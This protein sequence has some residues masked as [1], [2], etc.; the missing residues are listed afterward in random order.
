M[1]DNSKKSDGTVTL[2]NRGQRSYDLANGAD[3]KARR[4]GPGATMTYSAEEAK[5]MEGY[6]ELVDITKLPGQVDVTALK[7]ENAKLL[8]ENAGLK[9]QLEAL[10]DTIAAPKKEDRHEPKQKPGRE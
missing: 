9:A 4:H 7:A 5:R 1:S 3:G 2:L 8:A 6:K 10:Q